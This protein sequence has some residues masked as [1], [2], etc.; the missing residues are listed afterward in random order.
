MDPDTKEWSIEIGIP[1]AASLILKEAGIQKG[2]GAS[3]T[4]WAGDVGMDSILKVANAKL[5]SSY[6][7]SLK[8][9]AKSILGTCLSLGIRVEG[10]TPREI[11]AE[12][13]SGKWDS[14]FT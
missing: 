3:G 1:S 8:S 14:R 11:T 2:S 10:M 7:S 6:S 9:V 13:D 4:E 12:I 5:D